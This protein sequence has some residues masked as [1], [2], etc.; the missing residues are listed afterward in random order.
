MRLSTKSHYGLMAMVD[1]AKN[2][3]QGPVSLME[4]STREDIS[5]G[6]LEQLVAVLKRAGLVESTRGAR[7]GYELAK[8]PGEVTV[9]D[10]VRALEGPI[11]PIECVSEESNKELCGRE[12][13]CPSRIVWVK[14]RDSMA[15][16]LDSTSLA[17]LI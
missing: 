6:Y 14:M 13:A 5:L 10:I 11:A 8:A 17:D 3:G 1:L 15:Q 4:I 9:G 16:A 12:S 7:G 2:Y